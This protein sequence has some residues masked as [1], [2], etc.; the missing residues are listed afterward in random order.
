LGKNDEESTKL[1]DD[2]IRS[3]TLKTVLPIISF[4]LLTQLLTILLVISY[5]SGKV[6]VP[7]YEPFGSSITG[8][9]GNSLLMLVTVFFVTI[10]LV[11]FVR[12]KKFNLIK[13]FL[14]IFTIFTGILLTSLLSQI[15]LPTFI[16]PENILLISALL[17]LV[18]GSIIGI[19]A[20][21]PNKKRIALISALILSVEV[22]TY[23]A[24]FIRPPTVFILPVAFALYDIYA[25]FV[26]PL[27]TLISDGRVA[28]GPLVAH[29]G[30]LE[31][32]LGDIVFYSFLPSVGLIIIG[33]NGALFAIVSTNFGL[34]LTLLMLR[35]RKSFPGLPIPVI[36]TVVGLFLLA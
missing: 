25:V 21:K 24:L 7:A 23:F 26:G 22:A 14:S 4:T 30:T 34:L 12:K 1:N 16:N 13:K 17:A 35:K 28:L 18:I 33:V 11:W 31:I 27:K 36:F 8:S 6:I 2:N 9:V 19:S 29:L 32:G 5:I 20:L 3:I 15:L 10:G